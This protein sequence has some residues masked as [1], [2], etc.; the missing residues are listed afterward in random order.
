M[1]VKLIKD[2]VV[3]RSK[4]KN[5]I[6]AWTPKLDGFAIACSDKNISTIGIGD[7]GNEVG[8]GNFISE[9]Y[10]IL[11]D[12]RECLSVIR[13]DIAIPADVSNWGGY[14]LVAALSHIWGVWRGH[15]GGDERA[16]MDALVRSGAVDGISRRV[17]FSVD[18]LPLKFHEAVVSGLFDIWK[19]FQI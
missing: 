1:P 7:G 12:Y 4:R 10:D 14:A 15:R 6:S 8:M 16:M 17:G 11:P 5:N 9:L 19:R 2:K 3:M 13:T 18:G